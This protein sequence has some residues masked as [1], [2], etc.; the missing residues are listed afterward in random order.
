MIGATTRNRWALTFCA[1]ALIAYIVMPVVSLYVPAI[2]KILFMFLTIAL[3]IADSGQNAFVSK[4]GKLI[5]VYLLYIINI[6]MILFNNPSAVL[7]SL[8]DL[9]G[10][11]TI[12]VVY[13]H[14]SSGNKYK[15]GKLLLWIVLAIYFITSIT[16]ILGNNIYP[17]ASRQL[18]TGMGGELVLYNTYRAMNIGGFGFVYEIVFLLV[19]LPFVFKTKTIPQ[20]ISLG[21]Y[22]LVLYVTYMT[23]YTIALTVS[24]GLGLFFLVGRLRSSRDVRIYGIV[25][26]ML[27]V[28]ALPSILSFLATTFDSEILTSRFVEMES[29]ASSGT[30]SGTSDVDERQFAYMTSI[31]DF[32]S[33]PLLGTGKNGG[34]H[35]FVLDNLA[36]Y[37]LIGLMALVIMFR[38]IFKL[39]VFPYRKSSFYGYLLL[40]YI[41]F[42]FLVIVNTSPL[43]MSVTFLLPLI[44]YILNNNDKQIVY[45]K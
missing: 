37:G 40:G 32:L 18:A 29:L 34:G 11:M 36:K 25:L 1:T 24:L 19:I 10:L 14:I 8:Y 12:S 30:T 28:V 35:S 13:L 7:N 27:V 21:L 44:S 9:M 17:E 15:F 33:S 41:V 5:L 2:F 45:R 6:V 43:Y 4:C 42:L 38:S 39:Y 20:L 16:T 26:G 3:L 23:Q 31:T 22:F